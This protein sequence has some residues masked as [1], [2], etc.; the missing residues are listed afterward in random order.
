[1]FELAATN[2]QAF[3]PDVAMT[4]INLGIF[5]LESVP[6]RDTSLACIAE[7]LRILTPL[8]ARIPYLQQ[9]QSVALQV[10]SAWE[11]DPDELLKNL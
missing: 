4:L 8:T 11:I 7:A 6:Q 10:T 9:Y 5:Y 2:P 1:M 3:L